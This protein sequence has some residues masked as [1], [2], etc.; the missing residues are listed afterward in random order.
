MDSK[1][2]VNT[3]FGRLLVYQYRPF[4]GISWNITPLGKYHFSLDETR[5]DFLSEFEISSI[6]KYISCLPESCNDEN[7]INH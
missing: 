2:F 3:D 5:P 4:A 1:Q 6:E 7:D